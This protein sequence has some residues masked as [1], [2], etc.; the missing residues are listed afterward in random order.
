M[1]GRM[2]VEEAPNSLPFGRTGDKEKVKVEDAAKAYMNYSMKKREMKNELM[3]YYFSE[4]KS[5][6]F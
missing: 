5:G 3:R 6:N 4:G 2:K 1:S